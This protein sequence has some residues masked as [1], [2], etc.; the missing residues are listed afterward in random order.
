MTILTISL[1]LFSLGGTAMIVWLFHLLRQRD[2]ERD[3]LRS[4]N[5]MKHD[6]Q[7]PEPLVA[8]ETGIK[9]EVGKKILIM[10]PLKLRQLQE[11]Y[12]VFLGWLLDHSSDLAVID[13]ILTGKSDKSVADLLNNKKC[14]K[15]ILHM[16]D[17]T[18]LADWTCNPNKVTKRYLAKHWDVDHMTRIL[19]GLW[20]YNN[21][22]YYKKK[23]QILQKAISSDMR[24]ALLPAGKHSASDMKS[25][26]ESQ[27]LNSPFC[28]EHLKI[29]QSEKEKSLK[30]S[31][32]K[33]AESNG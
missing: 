6:Y 24:R 18:L 33:E 20:E 10:K 13:T 16:L 11:Y 15:K 4:C 19:F 5:I 3:A 7:V 8:A 22:A 17:K 9:I 28:P 1:T 32:K 25:F 29:S 31:E 30:K 26:Y 2:Q 27:L 21:G 12:K 14:V 23:L